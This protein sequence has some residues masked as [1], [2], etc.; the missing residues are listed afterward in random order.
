MTGSDTPSSLI[1]LLSVVMFW[2]TAFSWMRWAACGRNA[3]TSLRSAPSPVSVSATSGTLSAIAAR[4]RSR[5]SA[6]R[7]R[8][9]TA[10]PTRA[11]PAWRTFL[12]RISVRRSPAMPS[13]RLDSACFM[14]TCSRKCTPPRR[15]RPRYIGSACRRVSHCGESDSRFSATIQLGSCGSVLSARPITSLARN[16]VSVSR[17]RTLTELLSRNRPVFSMPAA[18]SAAS[19]RARVCVSTFSVALPLETCTAGASPKKFGS[20]YSSPKTSAIVMIAYF[21]AG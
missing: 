1:R 16:W 7:K 21:Q 2:W 3:A 13:M 18:F 4:A 5:V 11:M 8:I 9:S 17:K 15:S 20:V 19:T 6:S 10:S 12:S 14:S